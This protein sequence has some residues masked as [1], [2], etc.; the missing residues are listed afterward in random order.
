MVQGTR[1]RGE[2]GAGRVLRGEAGRRLKTSAK[3]DNQDKI[4]PM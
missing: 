2:D 4:T 3:G 1:L